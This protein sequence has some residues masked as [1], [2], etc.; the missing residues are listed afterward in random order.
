ML[1][2]EP[3]QYWT[4]LTEAGASLTASNKYGS[5][6]KAEDMKVESDYWCS[7]KFGAS[8]SPTTT[9]TINF[10]WSVSAT[11]FRVKP[12]KSYPMFGDYTV[13]VDGEEVY[14][15]AVY[16]IKRSDG[17]ME[18][19]FWEA[20][21][22]EAE[23]EGAKFELTIE[24]GSATRYNYMCIQH[25]EMQLVEHCVAKGG[26]K[27]AFPVKYKG[28]TYTTCGKN[29]YTKNWCPTSLKT[30]GE[31]EEWDLCSPA[32]C[33]INTGDATT[34]TVAP[35]N[36]PTTPGGGCRTD[37]EDK[38]EDCGN[39]KYMCQ[40]GADETGKLWMER[41][42]PKTCGVCGGDCGDA[43]T[44]TVAPTIKPTTPDCSWCKDNHED[45]AGIRHCG[46]RLFAWRR[47]WCPKT[48]GQCGSDCD[49]A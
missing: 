9:I 26:R 24:K 16:G 48:C 18:Y 43:T 17:W 6:Y 34:P 44:P 47:R 28:S 27:C 8:E 42:C 49:T 3:G 12:Y 45:C 31:Y 7:K 38:H 21:W 13:K 15:K 14:N 41:W 25:L 23:L 19:G 10:P 46:G 5:T 11:G 33:T 4:S 1:I 35:T 32:R 20:G 29:G 30:S 36:K 2:K 22:I 40:E 37:C 39:M